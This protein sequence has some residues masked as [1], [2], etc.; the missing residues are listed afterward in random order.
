MKALYVEDNAAVREETAALLGMYFDSVDSA[1]DGEAGL[2]RFLRHREETGAFY[3]VVV[4]DIRMPAMDGLAMSRRVLEHDPEALIIIMSAYNDSAYLMELINLGITHFILKP[5]QI[6]QF[7][8]QM[9]RAV[10]LIGERKRRETERESLLREQKRSEAE[11]RQKSRFLAHMSHEIRT[12]LNAVNGFIA[13]LGSMEEDPEKKRYLSLVKAAS[14]SLLGI[15]GDVLDMS[16][17][18]HNV[19]ALEPAAFDPHKALGDAAKLFAANAVNKN[20]RFQLHCSLPDY[21]LY[22]DAF[23]LRQ[24]LYHLLSNAVKFTPEDGKI[25]CLMRY[26]RGQLRL[27][28]KDSGPGIRPEQQA[29]LFAPFTQLN[30]SDET[31]V[32]GIGLGLTLVAHL[33]RLMEGCVSVHSIRGSG[34]A[35]HVSVPLVAAQ[36]EVA[37]S[38]KR[39][40]KPGNK[41]LRNRRILVVDDQE[42]N[43]L[44]AGIVLSGAGAVIDEAAEG[45]GAVESVVN[46][47][48][49]LIL[50]DENMPGMSGTETLKRLRT[51]WKQAG[52]ESCP[53]V[54]VTANA[55]KGDRERFLQAGMDAYLPKPVN[56][57][58]LLE[59]VVRAIT[60][61]SNA[62]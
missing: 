52:Q 58:T 62:Q 8:M 23:R 24:I 17:I 37:H 29:L 50:L 5:L 60:D 12:P 44:F 35:F 33:V 21:A 61:R 1:Q 41:P 43:R 19:L 3:D 31:A 48:Y 28:V 7:A 20:M 59:T 22:G 11:S 56:P 57:D 9:K 54:M 6:E 16:R 51:F 10:Q 2:K 55:L 49:D 30:A 15:V 14:D 46:H 38:E 45:Y 32:E 53:V 47:R 4:T 34:T 27:H 25:C 13:L 42:T 18:E 26:K 39:L 36:T 40:E